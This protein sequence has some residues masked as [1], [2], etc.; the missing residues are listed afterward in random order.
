MSAP[1]AESNEHIIFSISVLTLL[2]IE[3]D[4]IL[5]LLLPDGPGSS[6]AWEAGLTLVLWIPGT[7]G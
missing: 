7:Q 4:S 3:K 1:S 5:L 2:T 6:E